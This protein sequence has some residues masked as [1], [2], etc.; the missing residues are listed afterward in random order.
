MVDD[1]ETE[2]GKKNKGKGEKCVGY[3]KAILYKKK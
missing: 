2:K 3:H 1:E